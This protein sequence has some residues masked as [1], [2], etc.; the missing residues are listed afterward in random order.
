MNGL[1][2]VAALLGHAELARIHADRCLAVAEAAGWTG[3]RL[4][5]AHE[6][7]ARAAAVARDT[8][9]SARH[10]DAARAALETEDD[11][12]SAQIVM[13]QLSTIPSA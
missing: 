3:W 1:L 10:V 2:L 13:D 12:E 5:S 9:R 7:I 6:G 4:A 8:D 11:P